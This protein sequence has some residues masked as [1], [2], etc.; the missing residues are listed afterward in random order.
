MASSPRVPCVQET[1]RQDRYIKEGFNVTGTPQTVVDDICGGQSIPDDGGTPGNIGNVAIVGS[2]S[3]AVG[4]S[5]TYYLVPEP[6]IPNY[7]VA[8]SV[9]TG[10]TITGTPTGESAEI[11]FTAAGTTTIT[12]VI[13]DSDAAASDS[14]KTVTLAVTV[15]A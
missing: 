6:A 2:T 1:A 15:T 11:N 14:P 13:T 4:F 9:D 5:G 3:C 10:A 12:A 7:T 8:W